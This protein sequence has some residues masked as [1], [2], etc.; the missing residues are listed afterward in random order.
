MILHDYWSPVY[1][2]Q[3]VMQTWFLASM[4]SSEFLPIA[5]LVAAALRSA[6]VRGV[7]HRDVKPSNIMIKQI[8][9]E[10][11][12]KIIDFGLALTQSLTHVTKNSP[13]LPGNTPESGGLS[14]TINYAAPEQMGIPEGAKVGP[15]SDVFGFGRTCYFALLRVPDPDDEEKRLLPVD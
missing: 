1:G 4:Q 13:G 7:Y 2:R 8:N 6:H 11:T 15:Y 5:Q 3:N 12:V 9:N 14:G 10:W